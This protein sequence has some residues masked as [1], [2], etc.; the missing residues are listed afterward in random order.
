M[1]SSSLQGSGVWMKGGKPWLIKSTENIG[2]LPTTV[3]T[4]S[5]LF[6]FLFLTKNYKDL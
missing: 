3:F 6:V 1:A 5:E 2:C 4:K